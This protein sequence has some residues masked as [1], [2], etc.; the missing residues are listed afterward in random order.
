MR[1]TWGRPRAAYAPI[2]IPASGSTPRAPREE[3][4]VNASD[5]PAATV[6]LVM[7]RRVATDATNRTGQSGVADAANAGAQRLMASATT[8]LSERRLRRNGGSA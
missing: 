1:I 5:V 6:P 3:P 2:V 7:P 8:A 4:R